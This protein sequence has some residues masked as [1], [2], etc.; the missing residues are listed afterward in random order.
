[1]PRSPQEHPVGYTDTPYLP[2]GTWRVHD[3]TRPAPTVVTPGECGAPP[4]DAIVLFDGKDLSAW[5]SGGKPAGWAVEGGAMVVNG[6]GGIETVRKFGDMQLHLEWASPAK[7]ESESQG[8]GNSGLF[9]MGRYEVQI[10]DSFENRTYSDGQAAA[11]YGQHPP[12][13]NASRGPG[14]W[15]SYD[16]VFHPPHFEGEKLAQPARVTLFHNGVLVQDDQNFIGSTRHREVAQYEAHEPTG[17]IALQD[18][19]NPVRFRNVWV[20]ELKP[21]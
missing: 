9:L 11:L 15:Q 6:S 18:H 10:L 1:M 12:L 3:A 4:S 17:P 7:V 2:G 20:R 5:T 8:R 19:G 16:V 21:E 14:E 13:V